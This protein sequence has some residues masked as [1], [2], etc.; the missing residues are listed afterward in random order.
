[1]GW[2]LAYR[3]A[4]SESESERSK[5]TH[6]HYTFGFCRPR[7]T[8]DTCAIEDR[9]PTELHSSL[10]VDFSLSLPSNPTLTQIHP[11]SETRRRLVIGHWSKEWMLI[12][13]TS[14][15]C[16]ADFGFA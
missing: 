4:M 10:V 7:S 11:R 15:H 2:A 14:S 1:M 8:I 12:Y 6:T 5:D 13:L 3:E 16:L 9:Y